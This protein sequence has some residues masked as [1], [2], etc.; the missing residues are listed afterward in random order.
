MG[1]GSIIGGIFGAI[2]A[3]QAGNT[4]Q[5][6]GNQVAGNINA[7]TSTGQANVS[8]AV[9]SGQAGVNAALGT[10]SENLNAAGGSAIGQVN[11]ATGTANL[12]LKDALTSQTN[13]LNPYLAAGDQG[14]TGLQQLANQP[15][16]S[17]NYDDYKN[18]PAYKFQTDQGQNA[19][20]NSASARGLGSGGAALKDAATFGE[21]LASTYYD[22]AFARAKST[23]DT[24]QNTSLANLSTLLGAGQ[25]ASGQ[26]NQATQNAGNQVANNT[27]GAGYYGGQTTTGIAQ[28]LAQMGLQGSEFN[29]QTGTQGSEFNANLGL[30]GAVDAGKS[31]WQGAEGKAAGTLGMWNNIGGAASGIAGLFTP[32]GMFGGGGGG[33]QGMP[34]GY[35][36]PSIFGDASPGG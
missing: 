32:G 33:V 17:F 5:N 11:A 6:T 20:A 19:I 14:V 3:H 4:L 9:Q 28:M 16:F 30:T 21:G 29:S 12:G 15:K 34:S 2:G 24:N 7:A 13:N 18:D 8:N 25:T 23:Y 35:V 36:P 1:L 26:F 31:L 27:V 10:N 22:N